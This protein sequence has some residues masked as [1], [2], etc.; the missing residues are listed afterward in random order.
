MAKR[1]YPIRLV[2]LPIICSVLGTVMHTNFNITGFKIPIEQS[3]HFNI[4]TVNALFGG[5]LY[6][7]YSLL[8]GLSDNSIINK[9]KNTDILEKRNAHILKGILYSVISIIS[10]LFI[11]L[12]C[13]SLNSEA[14]ESFHI[15]LILNFEIV[16]LC[17]TILYFTIS[18]IEMHKLVSEINKSISKK[19]DD[20]IEK[21]K[22]KIRQHRS[23]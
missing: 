8:I 12:K 4:L 3:F 22:D 9:I 1:F 5:F 17:F 7:N 2:L 11:V 15:N 20:E 18:L 19:S 13:N 21:I 14:V 16:F 23:N 10:A 6:T